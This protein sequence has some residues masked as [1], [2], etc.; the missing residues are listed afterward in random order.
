MKFWAIAYQWQEDIY[1]DFK[2]DGESNDLTE[3]CFLPTRKMA[4]DFIEEELGTDFV[5][6]E[7]TVE[8]LEK[9]G[10]WTHT[11][12]TVKRWDQMDLEV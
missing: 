6:V 4:E 7:I 2:K 8:V 5:A 10:S 11:R 9:N 1:Y 12:G 3:A